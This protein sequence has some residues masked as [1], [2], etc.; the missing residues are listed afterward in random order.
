MQVRR[1][2]CKQ[3]CLAILFSV[4]ALMVCSSVAWA[5]VSAGSGDEQQL[6]TVVQDPVAYD[7]EGAT[8][9]ALTEDDAEGQ[10][11][12]DS[13]PDIPQQV[14]DAQTDDVLPGEDPQSDEQ[15]QA[16]GLAD[17]QAEPVEP[18]AQ[19][20][21]DGP[22]DDTSVIEAIPSVEP[23]V[24]ASDE[25][26]VQTDIEPTAT[27]DSALVTLASPSAS[28]KKQ[29]VANGYYVIR[30]GAGSQLVLDTQ[31][32]KREKK[33][34]VM[35]AA[36]KG[37]TSQSWKI[38]Y[39]KTKGLYQVYRT[40]SDGSKLCLNVSHAEAKKGT[41]VLLWTSG[42]GDA[43]WWDIIADGSGFV[44]VS[45]LKN[46]L[47][48]DLS[49]GKAVDGTNVQINT[50]SDS[51][52][53][54]FYLH[55]T[56]P[57][58]AKSARVIK[59]GTY[60][61][62]CTVTGGTSNV[63]DIAL[64]SLAHG[65]NVQAEANAYS[66]SQRFHFS[67]NDQGYYEIVNVGSGR[68]LH[69]EKSGLLPGT[70]VLQATNKGT[71]AQQWVVRH[72]ANGT[73]T[74][75]NR[76]NGLALSVTGSSAKSGAN[77]KLA[78]PGGGAWRQF[79]LLRVDILPHGLFTI[80][81]LSDPAQVIEIKG[82]TSDSGAPA[83]MY[84]ANGAF[85]QKFELKRVAANEYRIRT[86]ASGGWLTAT[87][88]GATVTQKGNHSTVAS[89]EN[90]WRAEWFNGH[91]VLVNEATGSALTMSHAN[92]ANGTKVVTYKKSGSTSQQFTMAP[93]ELLDPG[94][95]FIASLKGPYL[96]I[97]GDSPDSGANVLV[98]A[99]DNSLGQ[100]FYLERSDSVYRIK[101]A[102]GGK[103]VGA[104]GSDGNSNVTQQTSSS[105]DSQKWYAR[106]AD[107]GGVMFVNAAAKGKVLDVAGGKT[108]NGTNVR[109]HKANN[110]GGQ[111][112]KLIKT[113]YNPYPD[114][115]LRA[116]Q[117]AN[118]SSSATRYLIVV[119]RNNT[120]TIIMSGGNGNWKPYKN[121]LCTVGKS[122]TPT[123]TGSFSVGSR[124]YS[125]GSGYTCYYWT[126]FYADYLF[127]SVLYNEGTRTIQ[128]GRLGVHAS[129]GCVRL[130]IDN[131]YW[132]YS[133][134]PSGTRVLVY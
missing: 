106:I 103:Y 64:G 40:A 39:D 121:F 74:L 131:A 36:Y 75:V 111:A 3:A 19:G 14:D 9:P 54:R 112:W 57:K 55:L 67:Y 52:S 84:K 8:G 41:N 90:T 18:E 100:Y 77:L 49:S 71:K 88:S 21:G 44:F 43:Q 104:V 86:A 129:H 38:V 24:E 31:G 28:G 5:D 7:G 101:S 127:H 105:A 22:Q 51:T 23:S 94:C 130:A 35:V 110:Y 116:M 34:N 13:Q 60:E 16:D 61:I 30:T 29:L 50:D 98:N 80:K 6:L 12:T 46:T 32:G 83:Q 114:Y 48:L 97:S 128:D 62:V 82:G 92:T 73:F 85:G 102:Y 66:I 20:Q 126:Q 119:D 33:A 122:S 132:I 58:V 81:A 56:K 69:A 25:M 109:I 15:P 27:G 120:H 63:A 99:K 123:V 17:S 117:R 11:A 70:N 133:N 108:A 95:Y 78:T 42:N 37:G 4:L 53:Q 1:V 124:G 113:T 10:Q 59:D 2:W 93:T 118:A 89:S 47:V 125:F 79:R 26:P 45:A 107:G 68:A 65:A 72:N 76:A 134:V 87:K 115:V 96:D 91:F